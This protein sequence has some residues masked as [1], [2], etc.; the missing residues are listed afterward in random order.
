[1]TRALCILALA[2]AALTA[3][4]T[5]QASTQAGTVAAKP[6]AK[7]VQAARRERKKC[8]NLHGKDLAPARKVKLVRKK[9]ADG[10]CHVGCVL[11][12]GRVYTLPCRL[13]L[14]PYV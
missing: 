7:Q 14:F 9:T 12:R 3:A 4:S 2:A 10:H 6:A 1:M 13:D 8:K 5:G 11:P